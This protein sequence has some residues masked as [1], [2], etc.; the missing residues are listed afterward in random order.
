MYQT[1]TILIVNRHGVVSTLTG[2]TDVFALEQA[3]REARTLASRVRARRLQAS[4]ATRRRSGKY[5][6]RTLGSPPLHSTDAAEALANT[7]KARSDAARARGRVHGRRGRRGVRRSDPDLARGRSAQSR[8]RI[9]D[10]GFDASGC[11][12][13]I[14]AGSATVELMRGRDAADAARMGAA[15]IAAASSAG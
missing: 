4:S 9:I 10:A 3:V 1:P 5:R 14:A 8:G 13:A 15:E 6:P 2:L 7:S 11:G 12:A